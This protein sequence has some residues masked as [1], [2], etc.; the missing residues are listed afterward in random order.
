MGQPVGTGLRPRDGKVAIRHFFHMARPVAPSRAPRPAGRG[1]DFR[2]RTTPMTIEEKFSRLGVDNA[3][4]QESLQAD[5]PLELLGD[6]LPGAPVDFSHGDVDASGP[7]PEAWNASWRGWRRGRARPIPPTGAAGRCWRILPPS[8]LPL[9]AAPSTRPG[10]SSWPPAPREPCS[11]PWRLRAAGG[12]GGLPGAGLLR[13]PKDDR[14]P[15][16]PLAAG[17]PGLYPDGPGRGSTWR[18]WSRPF[19]PARRSS[20]FPTPTTPPAL[21]LRSMS[22]GPSPSWP[23]PMG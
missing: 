15:G 20:C 2:E 14:I 4:G 16:R 7:P 17:A 11:W 1:F 13:Q 18:R 21:C 9:P 19:R 6:P 8:C 5:L 22:S 3:P 10:T 12:P 23:G